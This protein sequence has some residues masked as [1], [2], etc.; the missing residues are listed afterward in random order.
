MSDSVLGEGAV[1]GAGASVHE[2]RVHPGT[3]R[4]VTIGSPGRCDTRAEPPDHPHRTL[5]RRTLI[6]VLLARPGLRRDPGERRTGS[7]TERAGRAPQSS[8][9]SAPAS[10]MD[11]SFR[12]GART[13]SR[14]RGGGR[15]RSSSTS[16]QGPGRARW[17]AAEGPADRARAKA[18]LGPARGAGRACGD[19]ARGCAD[20]FGGRDDPPARRGRF[21]PPATST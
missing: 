4:G 1:V 9:C 7:R 15:R 18:G 6:L 16:T 19:P 14:S 21:V 8:V 17:L 5:S 2:G 13:G 12:N 11:S 3:G 20:G 10:G